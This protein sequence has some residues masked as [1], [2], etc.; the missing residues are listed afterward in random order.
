MDTFYTTSCELVACSVE[1]DAPVTA[2]Q[3]QGRLFLNLT[4]TLHSRRKRHGL[5]R[6][7]V[8]ILVVFVGLTVT[9]GVL[10]TLSP[11]P[12]SP[13]SILNL[14]A[15][16]PASD[17]DTT[18]AV[19]RMAE[20]IFQDVNVAPGQW[21]HIDVRLSGTSSGNAASLAEVSAARGVRGPPDHFVICNGLGGGDGEIEVTSRWQSQRPAVYAMNGG[22]DRTVS[23]AVVA[24]GRNGQP[25]TMQIQQLTRLLAALQRRLG[26]APDHVTVPSPSSE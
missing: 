6:A 21:T 14:S 20:R 24:D 26:I 9:A 8:V 13:D 12:L 7:A 22:N 19:D 1:S 5:S 16:A 15:S 23:I 3:R 25:S 2:S 17:G 4:S 10:W 18:D 11:L